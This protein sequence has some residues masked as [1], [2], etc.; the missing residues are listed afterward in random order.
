M[1]EQNYKNHLRFVPLYHFITSAIIVAL[2]VGSVM[3]LVHACGDRTNG[4]ALHNAMLFFAITI[5]LVFVWLF[6]RSFALKVQD[7]A[8]RAE[9]NF[10]HFLATGKPQHSHLKMGQIIALRFAGDDEYIALSKR[11]VDENMS[12]KDIKMAITNW[13]ADHNRV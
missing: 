3:G 5:A 1:R 2:L 11:A 7:R 6:A 13:K 9:E 12:P 8:I 4:A 10:R